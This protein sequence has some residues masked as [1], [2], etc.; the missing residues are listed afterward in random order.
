MAAPPLRATPLKLLSIVG[1]AA[2]TA[3]EPPAPATV[4][5]RD[6]LGIEIVESA[7]P[8]WEDGRGW[9][10]G[11]DPEVVIGA[12]EGDERYLFDRITSVWTGDYGVEQVRPYRVEKGRSWAVLSPSRRE[13]WAFPDPECRGDAPKI[14]ERP[15]D[16]TAWGLGG[17]PG[18]PIFHDAERTTPFWSIGAV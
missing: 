6:S 11:A 8:A 1:A 4:S 3:G 12:A 17:A 16:P 14:P 10:L 5:V 15:R 13:G 9:R 18:P 7:A 2:C